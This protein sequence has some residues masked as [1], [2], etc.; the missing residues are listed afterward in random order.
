[1]G[2]V[3]RAASLFTVVFLVSESIFAT[4]LV[5]H[6]FHM[7]TSWQ[8][9]FP[10]PIGPS[11]TGWTE[12]KHVNNSMLRTFCYTRMLLGFQSDYISIGA[13]HDQPHSTNMLPEVIWILILII[14]FSD[15][16]LH[17]WHICLH[18]RWQVHADIRCNIQGFQELWSPKL[19]TERPIPD[20]IV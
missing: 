5:P 4:S 17:T 8:L 6:K 2:K 1:M 10:I 11:K 15:Q 7:I 9:D 13:R 16:I 19:I 20:Q 3:L 18:K 12:H 14:N